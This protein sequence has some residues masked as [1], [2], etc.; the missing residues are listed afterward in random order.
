M[1]FELWSGGVR[2]RELEH[3]SRFVSQRSLGRVADVAVAAKSI[4]DDCVRMSRR[5]RAHP[6]SE[7]RYHET[8]LCCLR[9]EILG[10]A[11]EDHEKEWVS[12]A[13]ATPYTTFQV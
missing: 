8:C 10:A 5:W 11:L 3:W 9:G 6:P 13:Y 7:M 1:A 2:G 4:A 12:L